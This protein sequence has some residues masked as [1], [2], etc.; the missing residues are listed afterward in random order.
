MANCKGCGIEMQN[1]DP[2]GIGYTPKQNSEYCQRCF[3]LLHYDDLTVSMRKGID[4]DMVMHRIADM[5]CLVLWVV[6]L[7]DFEG[8]MIPQVA[9]FNTE[10]NAEREPYFV[11][12]KY[13]ERYQFRQHLS[14]CKHFIKKKL[15]GR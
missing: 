8:S 15:G 10:F 5:D 6:D 11:L 14:G 13:S 12:T 4:P 7:F 2:K 9:A 1:N 3:R